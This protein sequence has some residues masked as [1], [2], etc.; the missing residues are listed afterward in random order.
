MERRPS[1]SSRIA[2]PVP[3]SRIAPS[4]YSS[5]DCWRTGSK[6]RRARR[7]RAGTDA[8]VSAMSGLGVGMMDR[9]DHHPQELQLERQ[10][11][12]RLALRLD[13]RAPRQHEMESLLAVPRRLGQAAPEVLERFGTDPAVMLRKRRDT[14]PHEVRREEL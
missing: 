9:I 7:H 3:L 8:G 5:T 14:P 4:G 13:R 11:L 10:R 12:E 1:Q 6:S 2:A